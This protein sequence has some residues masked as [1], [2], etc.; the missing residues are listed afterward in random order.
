MYSIPRGN[1]VTLTSDVVF[2]SVFRYVLT[3][4]QFQDGWTSVM[5]YGAPDAALDLVDPMEL[6]VEIG[7]LREGQKLPKGRSSISI[8][9]SSALGGGYSGRAGDAVYIRARSFDCGLANS[10]GLDFSIT[11]RG[12]RWLQITKKNLKFKDGYTS[13]R[14]FREAMLAW[15]MHQWVRVTAY[16]LAWAVF[17]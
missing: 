16:N 12:S 6:A 15:D 4:L 17:A 10:R 2:P 9:G 14:A 3:W 8:G 7:H 5:P 11:D 13:S 1:R